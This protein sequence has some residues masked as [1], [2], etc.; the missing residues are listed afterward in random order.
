MFLSEGK[1]PGS[2]CSVIV[3]TI[4]ELLTLGSQACS[5]ESTVFIAGFSQD[6]VAQTLSGIDFSRKLQIGVGEKLRSLAP[7][8]HARSLQDGSATMPRS[9][10][11]RVRLIPSQKDR[12]QASYRQPSSTDPTDLFFLTSG[13]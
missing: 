13:H 7:V 2:D 11:H 4:E 9:L 3:L 6:T 1:K 8:K 12:H 5:S 10:R